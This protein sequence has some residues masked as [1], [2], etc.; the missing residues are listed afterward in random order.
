MQKKLFT[1]NGYLQTDLNYKTLSQIKY[2]SKF[3]CGDYV[4]ADK[5]IL[6]H[7]SKYLKEM[8]FLI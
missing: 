6:L 4:Q 3:I 1:S 5:I 8:E 2:F 7:E